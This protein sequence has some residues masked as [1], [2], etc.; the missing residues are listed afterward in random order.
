MQR[1][2][3][4]AERLRY[5]L[6]YD[7][8]TGMFTRRVAQCNKVKVGQVFGGSPN[9]YGYLRITVDSVAYLAHRLAWLHVHGAWPPKQMDHVNGVR[10]DNRVANLR[11]ATN[12][13]N[14]QNLSVHSTQARSGLL[15]AHWSEAEQRWR[16]SIQVDGER[17]VLGFFDTAEEAHQAYMLAKSDIHDFN[18]R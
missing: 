4:T 16:S 1:K 15:G 8:G 5:L 17:L 7:P 9:N 6:D 12:S 3:L 10:H 18:A 2:E 11:A 13:Q 14:R